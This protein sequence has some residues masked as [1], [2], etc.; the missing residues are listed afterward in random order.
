MKKIVVGILIFCASIPIL[1]QEQE[2]WKRIVLSTDV[3]RQLM[4]ERPFEAIFELQQSNWSKVMASAKGKNKENAA[5]TIDLPNVKGVSEQFLV[6]ETSNF[7]PL[8]QAQFP[9]IRSFSGKGITDPSARVFFSTS[10][11]GVQTMILRNNSQAEFIEPVK[12][13][14]NT[15]VLYRSDKTDKGVLP[16]SCSTDEVALSKRI[17]NI[18]AKTTVS[19]RVFRTF[20][21]ALSCTG[22]YTL[23][24]GGTK[25][26]A[27]AAMNATM[28]RVNGVFNRDLAL[29]L[30]IIP[31]NLDVIYTNATSD[32]YDPVVGSNAPDTW[33][34]QLQ[35]TLT[36]TI[37]EANYDIGHLFGASGGGGN[38]GCIGCVCENGRKGSAFT[39]PSNNKPEGDL[40]DID[41]VAHEF[42]HQLGA[43]HTFSHDI[44][45]TGSN[46]EPGSGSTIMGYAGITDYN[47]QANSD[48]YFTYASIAQIQEN[49]VTKTCPVQTSI[50]TS[51][52]AVNAGPDYTIPKSTP[53]LLKGTTSGTTTSA[54]TYVWEQNDTAITT[55]GAKSL[56][57]ADKPDGPLFRSFPPTASLTRYFPSYDKVLV[58]RFNS[59][60]ESLASIGRTLTFVFTARD[61]A[62]AGSGQTASDATRITVSNTVG[63]FEITAPNAVDVSWTPGSTQTITWN[64][65][66]SNTLAG[67]SAVNIKL[68]TDGGLTFPTTLIANTP[69]DGSQF[70]EVPFVSA[71]ECRILVEPVNSVFYA[72]N[73]IPFAIGYTTVS[74]CNTYN[75]TAPI[76]IPDGSSQYVIREIT[77]PSGLG[78]IK[79]V[80]VDLVI[81]HAYLSDVELELVSP[82]KQTVRLLQR[83]CGATNETLRLKL[84]DSGVVVDCANTTTQV[85]T[86]ADLLSG[87]NGQDAAGTWLLRVRDRFVGDSGTVSAASVTVCTKKATLGVRDTMVDA[88]RL[89]PNPS[90]GSCT[91]QFAGF[92]KGVVRIAMTDLLGRNVYRNEFANAG[93]FDETID[94]KNV[95]A[96]VYLLTLEDG[97]KKIVRKVIFE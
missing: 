7:D 16:L 48:D 56:A 28:T 83:I 85:I 1:A 57:I 65:N 91:I 21:L 42:G 53:F 52:F 70:V 74:A 27:L 97:E 20:R 90:K 69:N 81:S 43:T 9:S 93:T 51:S 31:N 12:G 87:F 17:T 4:E 61:N 67:A 55:F 86:P 62:L 60:W 66:G 8:L 88:V 75:F 5:T 29:R 54:F 11:Q 33:N 38:A 19:D 76:V 14:A 25:E 47:V 73:P 3:Q 92:A 2:V 89:F 26:G 63:P 59:E 72:I 13:T 23:Y 15:Y 30:V 49:L 18:S 79:E 24:H 44:E 22:E 64:V 80:T 95:A 36:S 6:W 35:N 82:T 50:T 77:V 45:D 84:D 46:I 58:N 68:S 94:F 71:L 78:V 37:G 39:S 41:F 40:F 96:G 32:P 34:Q 10:E